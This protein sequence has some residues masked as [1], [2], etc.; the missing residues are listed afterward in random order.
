MSQQ[1]DMR[2][3]TQ[4]N[5]CDIGIRWRRYIECLVRGNDL[6][7]YLYI[8]TYRNGILCTF[9]TLCRSHKRMS[10]TSVSVGEDT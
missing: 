5:E 4:S 1:N 10:V 7:V 6:Y 8:Y 3:V 9:A 2:H